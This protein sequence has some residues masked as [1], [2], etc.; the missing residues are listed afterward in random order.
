MYA[1]SYIHKYRMD[2]LQLKKTLAQIKR[3]ANRLKKRKITLRVCSC[4]L[5]PKR[6]PECAEY[7][8]IVNTD[9]SSSPGAHWQG[10]WIKCEREKGRLIKICYF[11]DSY[12]RLPEND[13]IRTFIARNSSTMVWNDRQ[14]QSF[15]STNCGEYCCLFVQHMANQLSFECFLKQFDAD[16]KHNDVTAAKLYSNSFKTISKINRSCIQSCKNFYQ[17]LL[18]K[19]E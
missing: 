18:K 4:D 11:F 6:L 14:C 19:N 17:C 5:L 7:G 2:T 16:F 15:E 13:Y 1:H 3:T 9:T 12:G 8:F 10:I